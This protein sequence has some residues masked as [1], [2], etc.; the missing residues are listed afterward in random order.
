MK[1]GVQI[2]EHLAR[3]HT[4]HEAFSGVF[5]HSSSILVAAWLARPFFSK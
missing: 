3:R 4:G 1:Q 5:L 2:S